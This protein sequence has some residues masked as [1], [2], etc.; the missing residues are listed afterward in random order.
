MNIRSMQASEQ[1]Q[2]R[3]MLAS[4]ALPLEDLDQ[5]DVC[6]IVANEGVETLGAVGLEVFG[7]VGLLRSL[8]VRPEARGS[9]IGGRLIEALE[10]HA[11]G[12]GL[13]QLV[14]LTQ[15][16]APFFAKRGYAVVARDAVPAAVQGSAQFRSLCPASATCM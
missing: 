3:A 8:V 13:N 1:P 7:N 11:R 12:S 16:A 9:S 14:L 10:A 15:T 2:V 4:A 6:F 5:A